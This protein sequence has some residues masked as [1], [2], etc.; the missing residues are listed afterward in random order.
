[1]PGAALESELSRRQVL[2]HRILPVD[3]TP[4]IP[5]ATLGMSD[6]CSPF[7]GNASRWSVLGRWQQTLQTRDWDGNE[8]LPVREVGADGFQM[9]PRKGVW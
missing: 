5:F 2:P 6:A 9:G 4:L 1:M 3:F 8:V 7:E